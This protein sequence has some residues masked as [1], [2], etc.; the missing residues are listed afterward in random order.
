MPSDVTGGNVFNQKEDRS[1]L[2]QGPVFTQPCS[3]TIN[4]RACQEKSALLEAMG[5]RRHRGRRRGRCPTLFVIATQNPI[6]SQGTYP[7]PEAYRS[8][9]LKLN[10]RHPPAVIEKR[11]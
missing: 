4:P 10:V 8:V 1:S 2:H 6:E 7:L 5:S 11:I 9:S 3:P